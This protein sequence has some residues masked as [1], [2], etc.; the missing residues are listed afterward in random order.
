MLV[1]LA[2]KHSLSVEAMFFTCF[3]PNSDIHRDDLLFF[4]YDFVVSAYHTRDCS[5]AHK[6]RGNGLFSVA[7]KGYN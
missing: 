5:R 4:I 3:F 1:M 7:L 6:G 2:H